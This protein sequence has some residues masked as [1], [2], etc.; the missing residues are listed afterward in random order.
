MT[1]FSSFL[2]CFLGCC[3]LSLFPFCSDCTK[4]WVYRCSQCGSLFGKERP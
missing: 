3:V 1:F 2:L 4:D